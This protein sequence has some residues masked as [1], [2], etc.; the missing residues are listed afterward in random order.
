[1]KVVYVISFF[2]IFI[3]GT[4]LYNVYQISQ[5]IV[6]VPSLQTL[7]LFDPQQSEVPGV[8]QISQQMKQMIIAG[9]QTEAYVQAWSLGLNILVIILSALAALLSSISAVRALPKR[10]ATISIAVI[11]FFCAG[12]NSSQSYFT[13]KKESVSTKTE[14]VKKLREEMKDLTPSELI[15]QLSRYQTRL[16]EL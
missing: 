5:N 4:G 9:K 13:Q 16:D 2:L 10:K 7:A 1:M 14:Q 11:T 15:Q 8:T 6:V 12:I 3:L